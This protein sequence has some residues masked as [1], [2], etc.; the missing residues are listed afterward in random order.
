M[1]ILIKGPFLKVRF[2]TEVKVRFWTNTGSKKSHLGPEPNFILLTP[3][4]PPTTKCLLPLGFGKKSKKIGS[5]PE[6]GL[7][8][9]CIHVYIY[10]YI[11]IHAH[12]RVALVSSCTAFKSYSGVQCLPLFAK[13]AKILLFL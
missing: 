5:G 3:L 11:Y 10:M 2:W 13:F 6:P 4:A 12:C 7:T 9:M 1:H 8:A